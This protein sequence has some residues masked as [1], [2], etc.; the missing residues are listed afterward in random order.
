MYSLLSILSTPSM[1][2]LFFV[3]LEVFCIFD[4]TDTQELSL[5]KNGRIK[6]YG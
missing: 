2:V 6:D 5:R 1:W 3:I 4:I